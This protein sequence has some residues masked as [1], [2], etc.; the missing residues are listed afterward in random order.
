MSGGVGDPCAV[1]GGEHVVVLGE[2]PELT[3][4]VQR[5][6]GA[7]LGRL[8]ELNDA[9]LHAMLIAAASQ[10]GCYQLGSQL[11]VRGRYREQLA[12]EY[13]LC[14][15]ALVDIQVRRLG[16]DHS[17]VGPDHEA[18]AEDIGRSAGED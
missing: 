10:P 11:A 2:G 14:R 8:G 13:A 15:S 1:D 4:L 18:K 7:E 17:L 3:Q 6:A 16:A 12:P 9:R 5:V